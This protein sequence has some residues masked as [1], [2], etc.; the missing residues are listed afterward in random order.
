[1]TCIDADKV[2]Q[3]NSYKWIMIKAVFVKPQRQSV[4]E[5]VFVC[6]GE[7]MRNIFISPYLHGDALKGH[8]STLEMER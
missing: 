6:E 4:P 8:F 3:A 5:T 1:M 7:I 2:I